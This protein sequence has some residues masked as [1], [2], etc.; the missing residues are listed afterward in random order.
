LHLLNRLLLLVC[1]L[2]HRVIDKVL[3]QNS[4]RVEISIADF[5][6]H[7]LDFRSTLTVLDVRLEQRNNLVKSSFD[8]FEWLVTH[9]TAHNGKH[10]FVNGARFLSLRSVKQ[11]ILRNLNV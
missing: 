10:L 9:D 8:H 7:A 5:V 1:L 6:N 11:L 2:L 3:T 4:Q